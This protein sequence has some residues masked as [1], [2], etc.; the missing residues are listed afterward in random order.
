MAVKVRANTPIFDTEMAPGI[1][2]LGS[3]NSDRSGRHSVVI[4]IDPDVMPDN[5]SSTYRVVVSGHRHLDRI[6][7]MRFFYLN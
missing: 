2:M 5:K 1:E 6:G 4:D 3:V 7:G